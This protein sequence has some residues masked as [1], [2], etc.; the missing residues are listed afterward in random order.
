[1][2]QEISLREGTHKPLLAELRSLKDL[3]QNPNLK[4]S[5]MTFGDSSYTK[6]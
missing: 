1:V 3:P 4:T 6:G 2:L 5:S